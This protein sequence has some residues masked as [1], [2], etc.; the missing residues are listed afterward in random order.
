[1]YLLPRGPGPVLKFQVL[2][3]GVDIRDAFDFPRARLLSPA[4]VVIT[5]DVAAF[6]YARNRSEFTA[7]SGGWDATYVLLTPPPTAGEPGASPSPETLRQ[8]AQD[9]AP[10]DAR[11]A[12]PPFWWDSMPCMLP[13]VDPPRP[14]GRRIAFATED[15]IARSLAERLVALGTG[16]AH[17]VDSLVPGSPHASLQTYPVRR[18]ELD[19]LLLGGRQFGFVKRFPREPPVVCDLSIRWP[20]GSR[21]TPLLDSGIYAILRRGVPSFVLDGDGLIRFSSRP[22]AP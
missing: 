20:Q 22:P 11:A 4:D 18:T 1:M 15:K 14:S 21:I 16:G 2:R 9:V 8:L 17:W 12:E 5:P 3:S 6:T 10:G 19:S 13:A 7:L